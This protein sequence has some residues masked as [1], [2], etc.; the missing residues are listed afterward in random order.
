MSAKQVER[1][2]VYPG[3]RE[4]I[5]RMWRRWTVLAVLGVLAPAFASAQVTTGD[6]LGT[7]T[8]QTGAA[9]PG[10]KVT[11]S[12]LGTGVT[13]TVQSNGVGDYIFT[14][15]QPG[16]YSVQIEAPTFKKVVYANVPLAAGDRLRED[17]KMETGA[18]EETV[19]VDATPP[20]LQTDSSAVSSVVTQESVQDLP[21]NGRN[22]I[23][24]VT[25]QAGVNQGPPNAIS[26]GTR[27]DDRRQTSTV[28]A[29]GQSDLFNNEMIDGMDNNEREQGFIG[30]RPSI[31]AIAEVKIDTNSFT[32]DT[33]RD[34][35]AVVNIIT[36]AGTNAYHGSAYE[37]FRNDIFDATSYGFGNKLPKTEYRQNQF[38]GSIGGPI[39]KNKTFF[40]ADAEDNRIIQGLPTTLYTVPTCRE[41]GLAS[42]CK[43]PSGIYDFTDNGGT[44]VSAAKTNAVGLNYLGLYPLPNAG[45][46]GAVANNYAS[47]PNQ[48]QYAFSTDG[49]IDQNFNNGDRLFARYSYNGVSTATPG[50]LPDVSEANLTI[51][52]GGVPFGFAGPSITK[53]QN[54]QI[55]Y[56][57]LFSPNLIMD[58]KTG[59]TRI[60]I[61]S[62]S[63]NSGKNVSSALG[64][65]NANTPDAIQTTGL[66]PLLISG[67]AAPG[68]SPFLPI[69]D[70]NNTFQYMGAVIYTHGKH[71]LKIG[72][73]FTRRQLNYFQQQFGLGY[74]FF[75][76]LSGNAIEDLV[77]GNPLGYIRENQ[78]IEPGYRVSEYGTYIQD[79]WRV[80]HSLTLN[81]GLRWDVYGALTE[82]HNRYDNF[83]YPTLTIIPGSQS[84]HIGIDTNYKNF[85]P[86][87]GFAQSVGTHTVVHGGFGISSYPIAIQ[88]QIQVANPPFSYS[89]T[90]IP[91]FGRFTWP[92]LPIP[93]MGSITNLTGNLTYNAKNFNTLYVDQF[94]LMVQR[95][96]AGNTF[97]IGGIGELG[98]HLPFQ[99]NINAPYPTGPYPND[100]VNGPPRTAFLTAAALPNVGAIA[101]NA[102]WATNNYY[103]LQAIYERRF[104][105]GL[106]FNANYTWAHGLGDAGVG[107]AVGQIPTDVRADYGN[108]GVDIRNRFAA[109]WS[110][111]LPFGE[112]A[113]GAKALLIKGWQSNFL[114][115]WQSGQPF[116]VIDA[117]TNVNGSA[118]INLPTITSDR[119]DLIAPG[120][121]KTKPSP[122]LSNWLNPAAFT[123]QP[124]G[125]LGD[126]GNNPFHGPHTR[127]ADLSLFKNI[128]VTEGL[129]AQ[130]RAEVFNIS[131]TPN[132]LP[133]N[134][135]ITSW[136]TPGGV[137]ILKGSKPGLLPG[138]VA[139]N[140]GGFGAITST[141]PNLNPRQFQFALKLLF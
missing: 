121:Y 67:Y 72:A 11:L 59:Y 102:P 41:R 91:C 60:V 110:Y 40:F 19:Q 93:T 58:L 114:M 14:L 17:G 123:P 38:G 112:H 26:S 24:L 95:E 105:K 52:P 4:E 137:P 84:P 43:T 44:A 30:V 111:Q 63:L 8:D 97:T 88:N 22:F 37:F 50:A 31:D 83:D 124:A 32:A 48:T 82:A 119:P 101:V 141:V 57:H 135:T 133:P 36:K 138:D 130:F 86:R 49:R 73:Q 1:Q 25:I 54:V 76:G 116:G 27:P 79:N 131:N 34:A 51:S 92:V 66:T 7:V 129:T 117:F 18:V 28:S 71:D 64:V 70:R 42:D 45:G 13:Q 87:V 99:G 21:L 62:E 98:R 100:S 134:A 55:S 74:V 15:L 122:S 126:E 115:F 46:A 139:T 77:L 85:Q 103:A 120:N 78:L 53:A 65:V 127:R 118:Q 61:D 56:T 23:N 6:V 69:L 90:C 16:S 20:L 68:D 9:I 109:T 107:T 94:N 125:T 75:V 96:V 29:N 5:L 108:S 128:D 140:G 80:T 106:G 33:G 39:R 81:L 136:Q 2:K 89:N 104:T 12:N 10:A 35:G 3:Y 113:S 47:G 132:F